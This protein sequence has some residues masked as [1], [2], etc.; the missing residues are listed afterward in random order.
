MKINTNIR[1]K[2][3]EVELDEVSTIRSMIEDI[4]KDKFLPGHCSIHEIRVIK[5]EHGYEELVWEYDVS[6]HGSPQYKHST[7]SSDKKVI[8]KYKLLNKLYKLLT[9]DDEDYDEEKDYDIID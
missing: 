1:L 6:Y 7:I 5:N 8:A 4:Y 9:S 2:D 3:I